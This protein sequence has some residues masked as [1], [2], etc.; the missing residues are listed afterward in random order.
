MVKDFAFGITKVFSGVKSSFTEP[1]RCGSDAIIAQEQ[2]TIIAI[3]IMVMVRFILFISNL[4]I[5]AY[6]QIIAVIPRIV[7]IRFELDRKILN[8]NLNRLEFALAFSP[9]FVYNVKCWRLWLF[10]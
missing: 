3:I 6:N 8:V 7:K 10:C 1:L 2:P 4:L 9:S 5:G